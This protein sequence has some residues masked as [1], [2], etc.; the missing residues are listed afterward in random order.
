[1]NSKQRIIIIDDDEGNNFLSEIAIQRVYED[2]ELV[3]FT[4]P[5]EGLTYIEKQYNKTQLPTMLFLDINMPAINGWDIIDRLEKMQQ[6]IISSFTI[7]ILSSSDDR[8]DK[9]R[10]GDK[11]LVK[12]YL[13]K[14]LRNN[15][16]DLT[17]MAVC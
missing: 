8:A 10:A 9:E 7:Y 16:F 14:P 15:I 6:L 12:G 11:R 1:M 17:K 2:T 4:N 5:E 3:V 13:L